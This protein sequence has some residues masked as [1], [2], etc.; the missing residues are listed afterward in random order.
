MNLKL[1]I[2]ARPDEIESN[3]HVQVARYDDEHK[4]LQALTKSIVNG[5]DQ[6]PQWD[7]TFCLLN[8]A[9]NVLAKK[10]ARI[11]DQDTI[12]VGSETVVCSTKFRL[13]MITRDKSVISNLELTSK[14][15]TIY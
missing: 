4:Y 13:Y 1:L 2:R 14:V 8:S 11:N 5:E 12:T 10:T 7:L 9:E 15:L 3:N 6:S